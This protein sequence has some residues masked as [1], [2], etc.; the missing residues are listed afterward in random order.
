MKCND[1]IHEKVCL[2][3]SNI[4]TDTYAYM[5]ITYD[6]ENCEH[7]ISISQRGTMDMRKALFVDPETYLKIIEHKKKHG[8]LFIEAKGYP[9]IIVGGDD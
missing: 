1:C 6:T 2:H 4:D 5:G 9:P 8:G 3:R 7:Y